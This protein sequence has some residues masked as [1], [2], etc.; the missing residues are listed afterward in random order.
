[1]Y[2]NKTSYTAIWR[3]RVSDKRLAEYVKATNASYSIGGIN[4]HVSQS[5]GY[6]LHIHKACIC[7]NNMYNEVVA[8][9]HAPAF[10]VT[11]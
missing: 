9:Y 1:M 11:A 10:E 8:E 4:E 5:L 2:D 6:I 3:G 7:H